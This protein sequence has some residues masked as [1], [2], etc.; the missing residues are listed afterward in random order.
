M[1]ATKRRLYRGRDR[2]LK[3]EGSAVAFNSNLLFRS[4]S[5]NNVCM[6]QQI[7]IEGHQNVF[8]NCSKLA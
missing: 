3:P 8:A 4:Y 2:E 7:F 1:D 5:V 6:L